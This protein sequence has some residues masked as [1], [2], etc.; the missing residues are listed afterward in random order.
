MNI[1]IIEKDITELE[2]IK[3]LWEKLNSIHLNKSIH[4]KDK[5]ENFTF[6]KRSESIYKKVQKGIIK[7]DL[8]LDDNKGDYVGYCLSSIEDTLG[9]VE[10]IFI[11]EEYRKFGLGDKLMNNALK[12]FESNR[13]KNIGINV[14]YAN[15]EALPFYERHGFYIG[16]Y[17]L[18]KKI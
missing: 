14:V 13:I 12:W 16:N 1:S 3:P 4:F 2:I 10:S 7:L 11:K 5:Y 15:D 8:L 9:E 6:E 17:I 18:K